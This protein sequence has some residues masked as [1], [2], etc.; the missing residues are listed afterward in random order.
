MPIT[1]CDLSGGPHHG[2][3]Y[4]NWSDQR[5]GTTDTDVWLVKSTNGGQNWSSPKRVNNDPAG[6]QQ[7]FTWMD[8]DQTTGYLYIVFYDR[9][10]HAN[11]LTDVYIARSTDGGISFEN[12][13]ISA[14]PFLPVGSSFFGDYSNISVHNNK[15]RPIW[16]RADGSSKS[17]WTAPIDF[18]TSINNITSK[19]SSKY[20][21]GQNFPNPFNPSTNIK[22]DIPKSSFVQLIIHD[23][24]GKEVST[25]VSEELIAGSYEVEWDATEF[26]SG[27]YVYKLITNDFSEAKKMLLIK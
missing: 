23:I 20:H 19:I 11:N 8:I 22:F 14:T 6:K 25:I 24:L 15:V 17:V 18:S 27:I 2:T 1:S 21:L 12:I 5:N 26:T 3:I 16:T 7:F 9:R 13:K 10:N 4:I